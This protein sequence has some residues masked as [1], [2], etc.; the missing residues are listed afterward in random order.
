MKFKRNLTAGLE[1]GS[2]N[3][4]WCK[5]IEPGNILAS[6]GFYPRLYMGYIWNKFC[7]E[8]IQSKNDYIPMGG[9]GD[10]KYHFFHHNYF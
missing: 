9:K 10:L 7:T 1:K 4:S 8:K 5:L 2:G 3:A 6:I